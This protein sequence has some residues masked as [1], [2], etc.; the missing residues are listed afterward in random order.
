M[1]FTKKYDAEICI[2][3]WTIL[4]QVSIRQALLKPNL[5]DLSKLEATYKAETEM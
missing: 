3:V 5:P 1:T 2:T 4:F